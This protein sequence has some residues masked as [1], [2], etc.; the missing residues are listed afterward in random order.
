MNQSTSSSIEHTIRIFEAQTTLFAHRPSRLGL[1]TL[2][3]PKPTGNEVLV[4]VWRNHGFEPIETLAAP[5]FAYRSWPVSFY[6]GGYDDSLSFTDYRP[7]AVELLWLDSR[8]FLERLGFDEWLAWLNLR[9]HHLRGLSAAPIIIATWLKEVSQWQ[10]LQSMAD[11]LPAV[12]FAEFSTVCADAGVTLLDDRSAALSG[13]PL[14]N[15]AQIILARALACHWLPGAVL[16][17]VKALAL[18]LDHTLHAGVLGEDGAH[19][20]RLT[21]GHL[22]LQAAV[23]ALQSRGVFIALVSRNERPDV[24]ALFHERQDYPL[25]WEDFSVTEVSWGDKATALVRI[26]KGLRISPDAILFVDDNLGELASVVQQLPQIHAV[27]ANAD[28]ELTRCAIQYYPGLWRW[29]L[30][31]DDAKRVQDLKASEMREVLAEQIPDP[32][33]YFRSLHVTL[34]F[35]QNS[36]EQLSRLADLCNKTNQFNLALRRFNQTELAERIKRDDASVASI[37]LADRLSDSGVIAVI[38]AERS[39]SRL[40]VE[41][42]CVSCRAMGRQLEDSIILLALSQMPVITGCVEV[43]FRVQD[44]PRNR[45]ALEW[46]AR[47]LGHSVVPPPGLHVI[48]VDRLRSFIPSEG[49]TI[50]QE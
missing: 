15:S 40:V 32:A 18:D 29:K 28:A 10:Q 12:Y 4:N 43:A 21:E 23:K 42:V 33:E 30:E 3:L 27:H 34:R 22:A 47:L 13:T 45:P 5:Y 17:P 44:G 14:S 25:R 19:G 8:R 35:R 9:V 7:A 11:S 6:I 38:V 41:E 37:Q 31:S 39:M 50:I 36:W 26:A 24:E 46:L 2:D 48:P 1:L 20:V 16:P 49:V